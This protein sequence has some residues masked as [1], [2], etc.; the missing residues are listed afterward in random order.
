[1]EK[2]QLLMRK[3]KKNDPAVSNSSAAVS[4][5]S[6]AVSNSS[7]VE[8][9]AEPTRSVLPSS[10]PSIIIEKTLAP[11]V[12]KT[13]TA[14]SQKATTAS[15]HKATTASSQKATTA[16]SQKATTAPAQKLTTAPAQKP[17]TAPAQKAT[18]EPVQKAT[19]A[20]VQKAA[21]ARA[22][23]ASDTTPTKKKGTEAT[24]KPASS[25]DK[26]NPGSSLDV[27]TDG[28]RPF[29]GAFL[30][31]EEKDRGLKRSLALSNP[32]NSL[33]S[34]DSIR[35]DPTIAETFPTFFTQNKMQDQPIVNV[36][37]LAN[38]L[39]L[40]EKH[41]STIHKLDEVDRIKC[42][43]MKS[44]SEVVKP[45]SKKILSVDGTES[46]DKTS[47]N[48]NSKQDMKGVEYFPKSFDQERIDWG[49]VLSQTFRS[50][51][52]ARS[53]KLLSVFKPHQESPLWKGPFRFLGAGEVPDSG[54][55][56]SCLEGTEARLA[57]AKL[58]PE[59]VTPP[60]MD[61]VYMLSQYTQTETNEWQSLIY[62]VSIHSMSRVLQYSFLK[63]Y[64]RYIPSHIEWKHVS[65]ARGSDIRYYLEPIW[66]EDMTQ[67]LKG[68][69]VATNKKQK[70]SQLSESDSKVLAS[71][72][73]VQEYLETITEP[74]SFQ[75]VNGN[76]RLWVPSTAKVLL[77]SEEIALID[78]TDP[79]AVMSYAVP[80]AKMKWV[81]PFRLVTF[82]PR[83]MGRGCFVPLTESVEAKWL[84]AQA[85]LAPKEL[86]G[87]T[88]DST[89]TFIPWLSD[90]QGRFYPASVHNLSKLIMYG[91]HLM[92]RSGE[93]EH[94]LIPDVDWKVNQRINNGIHF[95]CLEPVIPDFH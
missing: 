76:M 6:P 49:V 55:W 78:K 46:E 11:I 85:R 57:L 3:L 71:L 51:I 77:T 34:S 13:T 28:F 60:L 62:P 19:T 58:R 17:T 90:S 89:T 20:Q 66:T 12:Q 44:D 24:K 74:V 54:S 91:I 70:M 87:I 67:T 38:V 47:T 7:P 25:A 43:V 8:S 22:Q 72:K 86:S 14:S 39:H 5:S 83:Q 59:K 16:S 69:T 32:Q 94:P 84:I 79:E 92:D 82:R 21:T 35:H 63:K 23:N 48:A 56:I 29:D 61:V 73:T 81:A 50:K 4:N 2:L 26:K 45:A 95:A 64:P 15:S 10:N 33:P 1:M 31:S 41:R 68:S 93:I 37:L 52:D 80:C 40:V 30:P 27:K 36:D 75:D 42:L 53:Q 18:T 9:K 88:S 65:V